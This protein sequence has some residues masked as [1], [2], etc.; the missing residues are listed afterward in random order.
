MKVLHV[1]RTCYPE[2]EGGL[3]QAIR[4]ICKG[5]SELGVESTIL[6][7]GE[8]DKD[9]YFEG[10]RIIV[11]KKDFEVS[12]NSFSFRLI[13]KFLRLSNEHD[14]VHYQYPWPTGDFL[15]FFAR[16][17]PS[18]VSYQSDIVKQKVLKL[19]Y[20]PLEYLFLSQV[21]R[22]VASSPQYAK[23]SK[24]LNRFKD[25][26][27]IIPL[28]ID[29]ASYPEP[30]SS[31][32]SYWRDKVGE[33]FFLF[34]GVL[35]YYKGLQY[36]LEAARLSNLP[37]VIAGEGPEKSNLEY[38][39]K[40]FKLVN[41]KMIGFINEED[42]SALHFLSKAFVFP[43]HLR[44][45]AFG[46]SIVEAL[47]YGRPIISC[48]IGTGSSYVNDNNTT[49]FTVEAANAASLAAAMI[50][51]EKD[52]KLRSEFARNAR[53]RF[54]QKFTISRYAESYRELYRDL[55]SGKTSN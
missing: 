11:L 27:D 53:M 4:Y 49:G 48:D 21:D 29:E 37:V 36:L 13:M 19:V 17:R 3:E 16:K 50:R 31:Q 44:S 22:I 7:L 41:V 25:K 34:V 2:T 5:C 15:S 14:L 46:I 26:V 30:C 24:N 54:E 9:Y 1:Y 47:M 32:V 51:L 38:Y 42:K 55:L 35:R 28:A 40:K 10:T 23:S 6:T 18:L 39:I 52:E 12:S 45:E 33:G 8:K 20:W 43:S